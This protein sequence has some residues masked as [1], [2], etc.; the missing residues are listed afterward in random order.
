MNL[1][2]I[3][4]GIG[5]AVIALLVHEL[6]HLVAGLLVG[7]DFALFAFGPVLVDR[8]PAGGLQLSWNRT[9]DFWGGVAATIPKDPRN[10]RNRFACVVAGGPTF[11]LLLALFASLILPLI[12]P[13]FS[14]VA[15]E[16]RWLRLISAGVFI[17]T[18]VPFRN[19]AFATDGLRILRMT[20]P[21]PHA[22]REL[23]LISLT[24]M[25]YGGTRPQDWDENLIV[26]GLEPHDGSMFECQ[27][28]LFAYFRAMDT[29]ALSQ[30]DGWL[31]RALALAPAS[32]ASLRAQCF[33]EASYLESTLRARPSVARELLAKVNQRTYGLLESDRLRALGALAI[34]E[35]DYL[36][37]RTLLTRGL[38]LSPTWA[39]GPRAWIQEML[40]SLPQG[41]EPPPDMRL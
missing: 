7:F 41:H 24:S 19:G 37:A 17:G 27:I 33:L 6:G 35:R 9:P 22:I 40:L 16:L 23:S 39:A 36:A 11:S 12:P 31:L 15:I 25:Q 34:C 3:I 20:R 18:I 28:C 5:G 14:N 10:V 30:A 38:S 4:L 21:G 29:K 32:Q 26:R 13:S 1:S 2:T 8:S